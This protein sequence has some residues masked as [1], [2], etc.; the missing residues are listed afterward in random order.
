ML[1][2]QDRSAGFDSRHRPKFYSLHSNFFLSATPHLDVKAFLLSS[3]SSPTFS[4][5]SFPAQ[6]ASLTHISFFPYAS[7]TKLTNGL[8]VS[9]HFYHY[10]LGT[11]LVLC[12]SNGGKILTKK[13]VAYR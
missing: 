4:I 3:L 12:V 6:F 7:C 8:S 5:F 11:K 13:K 1:A 9:V 10:S 2:N